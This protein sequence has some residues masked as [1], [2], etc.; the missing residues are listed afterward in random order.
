M[1]IWRKNE[2]KLL[3]EDGKIRAIVIIDR[4]ETGTY[5]QKGKGLFSKRYGKN[6]TY[7]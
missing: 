1:E 5:P 4:I 2:R 6:E 3:D 7:I